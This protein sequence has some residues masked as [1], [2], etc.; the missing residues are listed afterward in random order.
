M[1][2]SPR[3]LLCNSTKRLRYQESQ[4]FSKLDVVMPQFPRFCR[5]CL[6]LSAQMVN[7]T[8]EP[9]Y[10]QPFYK[11]TPL[12]SLV[13][14]AK[15][16]S[17]FGTRFDSHSC[18][19]SGLQQ[20]AIRPLPT[21]FLNLLLY[22]KFLGYPCGLWLCLSDTD[23]WLVCAEDT[24]TGVLVGLSPD[25]MKL[26][27]RHRTIALK[28]ESD[29]KSLFILITERTRS[30]TWEEYRESWKYLLSRGKESISYHWGISPVKAKDLK[31][32]QWDISSQK[33]GYVEIY[34]FQSKFVSKRHLWR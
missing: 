31:F 2:F 27:A 18:F 15:P 16:Y 6:K 30:L 25:W 33:N 5:I 10:G 26:V 17:Y 8:S 20:N 28:S 13:Y 32:L 9:S 12:I 3:F 34:S 22:R 7:F 11:L 1:S 14:G 21:L 23:A 4:Y 19:S 24:S 29:W